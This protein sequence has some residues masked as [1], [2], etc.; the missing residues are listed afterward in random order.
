M[1]FLGLKQLLCVKIP[2]AMPRA[3]NMCELLVGL[4]HFVKVLVI[5]PKQSTGRCDFPYCKTKG[6]KQSFILCDSR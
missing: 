4:S 5:D 2:D 3:L 1:F 6:F